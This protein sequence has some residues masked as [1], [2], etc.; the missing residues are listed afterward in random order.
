MLMRPLLPRQVWR[1][2]CAPVLSWTSSSI[3]NTRTC[4]VGSR[5]CSA[6]QVG[7][8]STC[9]SVLIAS[10]IHETHLYVFRPHCHIPTV[11]LIGQYENVHLYFKKYM[12]SCATSISSNN[13][14]CG[15]W[16]KVAFVMCICIWNIFRQAFPLQYQVDEFNCYAGC[17]WCLSDLKRAFVIS[18]T[19]V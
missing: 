2:R 5:P 14:L 8:T 9:T 12:K 19:F 11:N 7:S 10:L 18:S 3:V 16:F 6:F 1:R 4:A 13:F 15:G 17:D